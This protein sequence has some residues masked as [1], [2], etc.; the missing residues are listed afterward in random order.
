M[1]RHDNN[2]CFVLKNIFSNY[3]PH[4]IPLPNLDKPEPKRKIGSQNWNS[5]K[6]EDK[7]LF[8]F[9]VSSIFVYK[10]FL[11]FGQ[12]LNFLDT[13]NYLQFG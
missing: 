2:H 11:L 12:E 10:K 9:C 4:V 6:I 8:N 3:P 13:G 1:S 5:H 7:N